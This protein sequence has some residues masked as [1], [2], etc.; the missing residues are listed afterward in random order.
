MSKKLKILVVDD[1]EAM[2]EVLQLRLSDWGYEVETA[3]DGR[4]GSRL[5]E[6]FRPH[7]VISD[8]VMPELSGLELLEK[9]KSGDDGREV[10]LITAHG[11]VDVAVEAMK[12]GA[13]DFITKPLNYAKLKSLVDAVRQDFKRREETCK[14]MSDLKK[15]AGFG[16]F[17]GQ[18]KAMR[19]VYEL[20]RSMAETDASILI[21]GESGTGKELAARTIHQLS[22][23]AAGPFVAVNTAAIPADLMESEIFGHEKGAFT[24]ATDVRAGCFELAHEGTLLLDEI[25]E[26]PPALQ[27]KLLRILEDGKVR[28]LGGKEEFLVDVRVLT[29]TNR[30]PLESIESGRLRADLYYRVNVFNI[31]LP[32]LRERGGDTSLLAQHFVKLFNRKHGSQVTAMRE[33]AARILDQ[34]SWPGN[35]RELRNVMERAVVLA[36]KGWIESHHLPP[37][38]LNPQAERK[39]ELVFPEGLTAAEA[40]KALILTTLKRVDNNKA[41]AARQLGLDVKT[42]RNKLKSYGMA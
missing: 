34:Y 12:Q 24:G 37:Y 26:M 10:I 17:V 11:T 5:A 31:H 29:A 1:E 6:R 36:G 41:E 39:N 33:S 3:R 19:K 27:P 20:I 2:L 22:K 7:L 18:S 28:R 8:V 40:E 32:P 14:L 42:I 13:R 9:L 38:L 35:V 30:D 16:D 23:R 15:G 4:E 25:G 21:T